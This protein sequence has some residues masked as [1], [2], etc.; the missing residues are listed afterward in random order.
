MWNRFFLFFRTHFGFS[1]RESRGFVLVLP[2]LIILYMIPSVYGWLL[3]K[4]N[5]EIYETYLIRVDSLIQ[6]GWKPVEPMYAKEPTGNFQDS[7]RRKNVSIRP[8]LN[9]LNFNEADSVVLQVVP[10]IGQTMAGRIV[11]FRENIGG[12]HDKEQI[13]E[14]YGMTE[15]V[16]DRVFEYF[17]FEPGVQRK[18]SINTVNVQELAKHPYVN[19]GTA[20][21]IVAYRDQHG[22]YT[23]PDD[24][25]KIKIF[26][27]D[28][29]D[30]LKPYLEF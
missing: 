4:Q 16:A 18:L 11:K 21:V 8:Q 1:R 9:R 26:N 25:L 19:Y 17:V 22:P 24:L 28:W 2:M 20:K 10:G 12:L 14:V 30:R 15:E 7:V 5:N 3:R 23:Q 29:V 13:L 27:E 6:A